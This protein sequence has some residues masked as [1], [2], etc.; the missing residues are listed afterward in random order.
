MLSYS[1]AKWLKLTAL[2]CA[3]AVTAGCA[4]TGTPRP[5]PMKTGD[6]TAMVKAGSTSEQILA[7]VKERGAIAPNSEDIETLRKSGASHE[8]VD[9]LLQINQPSQW[10]YVTPPAFS[11]YYGRGGWYWVDSFGWPVYPQP[12]W[13]PYYRWNRPGVK[14]APRSTAPSTSSRSGAPSKK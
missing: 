6:I 9:Q 12:Y 5:Q 4:T 11:F 10:V 14:E 8:T 13:G 1:L 3:V 7:A 2:A